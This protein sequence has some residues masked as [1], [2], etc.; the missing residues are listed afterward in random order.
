MDNLINEEIEGSFSIKNCDIDLI[1]KHLENRAK[2]DY[3]ADNNFFELIYNYIEKDEENL[4][5]RE[6]TIKDEKM[7]FDSIVNDLKD[8]QKI[9]LK[10]L[11][12]FSIGEI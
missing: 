9:S 4:L 12:Y 8:T 3:Y 1:K 11:Q 10:G 2:V 5:T 7:N 6:S